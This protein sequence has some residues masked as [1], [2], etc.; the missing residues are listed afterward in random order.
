MAKYILTGDVCHP[1]R[2]VVEADSLRDAIIKAE[3]DSDF[4]VFSEQD[5]CLLFEFCGDTDGGVEMVEEAN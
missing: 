1:G 4:R 2:V 5:S 3:Y